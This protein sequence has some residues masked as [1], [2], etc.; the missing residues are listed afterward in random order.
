MLPLLVIVAFYVPEQAVIK[1][2]TNVQ[3]AIA[4][5]HAE[6]RRFRQPALPKVRPHV[7][8]ITKQLVAHVAQYGILDPVHCFPG[9]A[10]FLTAMRQ[11]TVPERDHVSLLAGNGA[12][13][14]FEEEAK[15]FQAT[16]LAAVLRARPAGVLPEQLNGVNIG[17]GGRSV[18]AALPIDAHRS[19][20]GLTGLPSVQENIPNTFL[21]WADALPFAPSSLDF[22]VSLHNLE[23]LPRPVEAVSHYLS[24]LKPGGG[25]GV[26][27]PHYAYAW[28][29]SHDNNPWGHRWE[30]SPELVCAMHRAF[31]NASASLEALSTYASVGRLSFDFVLRKR[32]DHVPF[33]QSA[34]MTGPTGHE[35]FV[36][37]SGYLTA[38]KRSTH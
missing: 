8:A 4:A 16:E 27:V 35:L 24:L 11:L 12:P 17:A 7:R 21:A 3:L 15:R 9:N 5:Q 20:G 23:H 13:L 26:V 33:N 14:Y 38:R 10:S 36:R 30:T 18:P 22:I 34:A 25:L 1:D 6:C 32:G 31:W 2:E 37:R 19:V 29:P 28:K